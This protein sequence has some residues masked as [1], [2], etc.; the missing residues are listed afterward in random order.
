MIPSVNPIVQCKKSGCDKT[1]TKYYV[2][3]NGFVHWN[4]SRTFCCQGHITGIKCSDEKKKK[5]SL[6]N[7]GRKWSEETRKKILSIRLSKR[8]VNPIVQ[9]KRPGCIKTFTKHYIYKDGHVEWSKTREY[10]F[11]HGF[12][13]KWGQSPETR[14][15]SRLAHLDENN[16]N[17]KDDEVGYNALH[18][19][20]KR[21]LPKTGLCQICFEAPSYDLACIGKYNRDL[22][23]WRWLCRRCHMYSDGR[24]K[25]LKQFAM[26]DV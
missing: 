16:I 9:C 10:C 4:Q 24:M 11:E 21:R 13:S 22:N 8:P 25:N 2:D 26:V 23:S 19:Y 6:S 12:A 15:K 14:L 17:W 1:F 7:L 20:V 5:I 18:A 3:K